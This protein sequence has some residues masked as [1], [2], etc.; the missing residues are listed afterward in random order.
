MLLCISPCSSSYLQHRQTHTYTHNHSSL[1]IRDCIHIR[2]NTRVKCVGWVLVNEDVWSLGKSQQPTA[3][4]SKPV[5]SPLS[6]LYHPFFT[7]LLVLFSFWL[8]LSCRVAHMETLLIQK[9]NYL[10]LSASS[11]TPRVWLYVVK[12]LI[13]CSCL[14]VCAAMGL[15]RP[16][17]GTVRLCLWVCYG[18]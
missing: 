7:N 6:I 16:I 13:A 4:L 15:D 10:H 12:C 9:I 2:R 8:P 17:F 18:L 11:H 5:L 3:G 14:F 1:A